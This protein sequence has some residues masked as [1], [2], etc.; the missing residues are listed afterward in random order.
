MGTRLQ[1]LEAD[2]KKK[3]TTTTKP[4]AKAP[5]K[6][7][8]APEAP[9]T[10]PEAPE[11]KPEDKPSKVVQMPQPKEKIVQHT[12]TP[13][14]VVKSMVS[15]LTQLEPEERV[16]VIS[17]LLVEVLPDPNNEGLSA[18]SITKRSKAKGGAGVEK[19]RAKFADMVAQGTTREDLV[20]VYQKH[21]TKTVE[22]RTFLLT[23][24]H[25]RTGINGNPLDVFPEFKGKL[26]VETEE[27][28]LEFAE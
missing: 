8:V 24:L 13:L 14:G 22:M 27:G 12:A 23:L 3:A 9:K 26:V 17:D 28:K 19:M 7:K 11:V 18:F 10:A 15:Y 5:A 4:K 1:K 6:P 21:F 16:K 20:G 2:L 25:M